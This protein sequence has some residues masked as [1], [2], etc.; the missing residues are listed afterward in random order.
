MEKMNGDVQLFS[1]QTIRITTL[2][3]IFKMLLFFRYRILSYA[4][5]MVKYQF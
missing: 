3:L 5:Q 4:K 2:H 1:Y